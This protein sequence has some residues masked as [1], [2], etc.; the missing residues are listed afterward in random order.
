MVL[1][2]SVKSAIDTIVDEAHEPPTSNHK[3]ISDH[4]SYL[5]PTNLV[6]PQGTSLSILDADEPWDTPH[7]HTVHVVDISSKKVIF[8]SGRLD[9]TNASKSIVLPSGK[10][11]LMDT[12]YPWIQGNIT[13]IPTQKSLTN[14]NLTVGAF[15]TATNEVKDNKDNDGGVHPGWFGYYQSQFPINGFQILSN[16]SFH[17]A[18]CKYCPGG[19]WPDIKSADNTLFVYNTSQPLSKAIAKLSKFVWDNVYI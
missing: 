9:Y 1:P 18:K 19:Y 15:Y 16:Y 12:K 13:V 4:N 11:I 3:H 7:P 10:Y 5:L 14:E 17:Y 2:S 8:D 6:I